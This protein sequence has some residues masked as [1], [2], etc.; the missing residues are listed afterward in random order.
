MDFNNLFNKMRN[1]QSIQI[2]INN[3]DVLKYFYEFTDTPFKTWS[4][5]IPLLG[6]GWIKG[7]QEEN[8][9]K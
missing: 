5:I 9:V 3:V 8:K 1:Q 2:H 4:L 6:M 7:S